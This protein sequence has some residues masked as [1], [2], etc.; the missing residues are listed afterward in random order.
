M[1]NYSGIIDT[2]SD[3]L[4][5]NGLYYSGREFN[6]AEIDLSGSSIF[7]V[8]ICRL[9]TYRDTAQSFTHPLLYKLIS[10]VPGA[11]ADTAYLPP[12]S[13]LEVLRKNNIPLLLPVKSKADPA[14]FDVIALSNSLVQELLNIGTLLIESGLETDRYKRM[15][16]ECHPLIILGG[17]NAATCHFL[18]HENSPVDLVYTGEDPDDI[19]RFFSRIKELRQAGSKKEEILDKLFVEFSVVSPVRGES[20]IKN[21]V[22]DGYK[23]NVQ[24]DGAPVLF[25]DDPQSTNIVISRGCP[26]FCS[27]CNESFRSKPYSEISTEEVMRIADSIRKYNG[28]DELSLFSFNFNAH[29]QIEGI[30]GGL[31]KHF[32]IVSLK[33]Q[34]FDILSKRPS[35]LKL[36]QFSGKT[37]I[38]CGLEGISERMRSYMSKDLSRYELEESLTALLS[39]P[40][41]TLKIFMIAAGIETEEDINEL[42]SLLL[43]I[44]ES[45]L[46]RPRPPR[47]VFSLTPLVRFPGT[48]LGADQAY[49]AAVMQK[50]IDDISAAV[51]L[52][53]F[54]FRLANPVYE[55]WVSQVLLRND[56]AEFY[57]AMQKTVRE[58][59]FIYYNAVH[60]G[61]YDK[62]CSNLK[63]IAPN[64]DEL[65]NSGL[66]LQHY[67]SNI[68]PEFLISANKR[69][70]EFSDTATCYS[71]KIENSRCNDCGACETSEERKEAMVFS[72]GAGL[73]V[74]KLREIQAD[75]AQGTETPLRIRLSPKCEGLS[76]RYL[77]AVFTS[78]FIRSVPEGEKYIKRFVRFVSRERFKSENLLGSDQ[79]VF[80]CESGHADLLKEQKGTSEF[81]ENFKKYAQGF[82]EATEDQADPCRMVISLPPGR[83]IDTSF[84]ARFH[85]RSTVIK[86]IDGV[87][88]AQVAKDGLKKK[89]F[90][91]VLINISENRIEVSYGE[92]FD[93][94]EFIKILCDCYKLKPAAL[95][96]T[97]L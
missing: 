40:V 97:N 67:N 27:F 77:G 68:K 25:R 51:T 6:T 61:F 4:V 23:A 31:H 85:I 86:V 70:N 8:L 46:N 58:T 80:L 57:D 50:I 14:D 74:D 9:S 44:K 78:A 38:T 33:S 42:R 19:V 71:I 89:Q 76:D 49:P 37:G 7:K 41:R 63:K 26:W 66:D 15:A 69:A 1:K 84:I 56:S 83:K 48:P 79:A 36:M 35:F 22:S 95:K 90:S 30:L 87:Y 21:S 82:G 3:K 93:L 54:E 64:A 17:S 43:F 10:S 13:D 75:Y 96:I 47:I 32:R 92:K 20:G 72:R 12:P 60:K 88:E 65:L 45:F 2:L 24:P 53:G 5:Q 28:S 81:K 52:E 73:T 16:D 39:S 91:K 94:N 29:S 11:F 55:Y 34:R 62:L 18:M 59:G